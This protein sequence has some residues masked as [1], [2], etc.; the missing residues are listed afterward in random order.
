MA[1]VGIRVSEEVGE[2]YGR[3]GVVIGEHILEK[4]HDGEVLEDISNTEDDRGW[5][6]DGGTFLAEG[7][8]KLGCGGSEILLF[9][10]QSH[11]LLPITEAE[12]LMMMSFCFLLQLL[13]QNG[14][15]EFF[16]PAEL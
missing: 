5:S 9:R 1:G 6:S 8:G 10:D 12:Y 14:F 7:D 13:C 2:G 4:L 16:F 3:E 11:V 15:Y